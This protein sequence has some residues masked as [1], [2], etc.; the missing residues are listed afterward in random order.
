MFDEILQTVKVWLTT[1][2]LQYTDITVKK[3]SH[4]P[5]GLTVHMES[6]RYIA[7]LNVSEP[8]FRPYRY[9]E[10]YIL[11]AE[12][13]IDSPPAYLF[14]DKDDD[15]VQDIIDGLTAGIHLMAGDT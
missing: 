3:I 13:E 4:T 11:D 5:H 7:Q 15:S 2:Q 6:G 14:Q 8:D 1:M 10:F 12:K 9:A